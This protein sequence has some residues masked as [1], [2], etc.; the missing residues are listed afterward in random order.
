[1]PV[2]DIRALFEESNCVRCPSLKTSGD[3]ELDERKAQ[4]GLI[5]GLAVQDNRLFGE[6]C[7]A[8]E[9]LLE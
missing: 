4:P 3:G 5:S 6:R 7:R 1:M 9:S 2:A 8:C